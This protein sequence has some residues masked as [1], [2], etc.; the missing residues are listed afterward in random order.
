M[1]LDARYRAFEGSPEDDAEPPLPAAARPMFDKL[2]CFV[3][4]SIFG[5]AGVCLWIGFSWGS[6]HG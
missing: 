2:S 3:L 5:V 4:V 6:A 1:D